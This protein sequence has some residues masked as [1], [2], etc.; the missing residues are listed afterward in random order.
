L[1]KKIPLLWKIA[2]AYYNADIVCVKSEV[3]RLAPEDD[4]A[5]VIYNVRAVKIYNAMSSL[6][7]LKNI[8]FFY[9]EKRASLGTPYDAGVVIVNSEVVPSF[10]SLR[11]SYAF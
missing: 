6:V 4:P 11:Q 7:G 2:L 1:K 5:I 8:F 10:L 9:F 3:V